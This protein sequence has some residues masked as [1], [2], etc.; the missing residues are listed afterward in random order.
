VYRVASVEDHAR[1][2]AGGAPA[3]AHAH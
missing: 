1:S 2:D 3:K